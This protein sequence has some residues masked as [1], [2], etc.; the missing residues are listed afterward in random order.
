MH[1]KATSI[2]AGLVASSALAL[3]TG[4]AQAITVNFAPSGNPELNP[5]KDIL[6]K[7][8][9]LDDS[10]EISDFALV[11][12]V[13]LKSNDVSAVG[14]KDSGGA[15][16]DKG[17]VAQGNAVVDPTSAN[18]A[19][20]LGNK[21]LSQIVDTED[22]GSF[23]M[24]ITFDKFINTLLFF[25]RGLNSKLGIQALSGAG[26]AIGNFLVL[27]S[28][29]WQLA[30]YSLD[31]TEI[32]SAQ[33]VGTSLFSTKA[34]GINGPINRLRLTSAADYKG[35]DFKVFGARVADVSVPE[36][37]TLAGIGL[38]GSFLLTSRRRKASKAS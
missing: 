23:V 8:V 26:E 12:Q 9:T 16:T 33:K 2:F 1:F 19:A 6:L 22:T 37:A 5:R 20:T 14:V 3:L 36:P 38:V 27:D 4:S 28:S 30:G 17:D 15:S 10:T 25:E 35:A 13:D 29:T 21:Y 31:T 18:I 34:L 24:D 7:S 11:S 32:T